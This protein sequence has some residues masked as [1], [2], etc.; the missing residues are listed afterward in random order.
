MNISLHKDRM[1]GALTDPYSKHFM[2]LEQEGKESASRG[3]GRDHHEEG[4]D[5]NQHTETHT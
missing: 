4:M 2:H 3:G 5:A 1:V